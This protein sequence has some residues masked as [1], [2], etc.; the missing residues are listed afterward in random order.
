MNTATLTQLVAQ[1]YSSVS[2]STLQLR[3]S[4]PH[5]HSALAPGVACLPRG[6]DGDL[7]PVG[8]RAERQLARESR[9]RRESP[10]RVEHVELFLCRRVRLFELREQRVVEHDV[11]GGACELAVAR[12]FHVDA[13][14]DRN[15]HQRVVCGGG[16]DGHRD[17]LAARL[18]VRHRAADSAKIKPAEKRRSMIR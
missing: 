14:R 7:G 15:G 4:A 10:G 18:D 17:G 16:R 5:Q 6:G 9:R 3:A 8:D 12:R 11:A 1:P 13:V 2:V